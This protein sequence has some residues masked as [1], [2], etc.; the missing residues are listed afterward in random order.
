MWHLIEN[1]N[2]TLPS[3]RV[4]GKEYFAENFAFPGT[5]AAQTSGGV[6][7]EVSSIP[8]LKDRYEI[9]EVDDTKVVEAVNAAIEKQK[10]EV[11]KTDETM[12]DT[13]N[14]VAELGVMTATGMESAAELG[15]MT[16]TSM[17]SVA[18]LGGTVAALEARIAALEAAQA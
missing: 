11:H 4:V 3:G 6:T 18:E 1:E 13:M 7:F 5:L 16:A 8:M 17:E 12:V 2:Y 15:T 10:T 9:E 14:A